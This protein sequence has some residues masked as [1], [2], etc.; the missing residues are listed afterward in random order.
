LIATGPG[1]GF[2]SG[3]RKRGM[4]LLKNLGSL[5]AERPGRWVPALG[6]DHVDA[7]HRRLSHGFSRLA[8]TRDDELDA[9]L[10]LAGIIDLPRRSAV[11]LSNDLS[12]RALS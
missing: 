3:V 11:L 12:E 4:P 9:A 5:P 2:T 8:L 1:N 7:A 10:A 6:N